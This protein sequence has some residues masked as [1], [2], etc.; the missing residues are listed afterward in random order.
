MRTCFQEGSKEGPATLALLHNYKLYLI[1]YCMCIVVTMETCDLQGL[2]FK[3]SILCSWCLWSPWWCIQ[4]TRFCS[5]FG[6]FLP[7]AAL[8]DSR[9]SLSDA[10]VSSTTR[11][12]TLCSD[13]DA[14]E[15]LSAGVW[16]VKLNR[17]KGDGGGSAVK[18]TICWQLERWTPGTSHL[19]FSFISCHYNVEPIYF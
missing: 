6:A 4:T 3:T 17:Q 2:F 14:E 16:A 7:T 9:G 11:T 12:G 18:F 1:N 8:L 13:G 19:W 15:V 10:G 5:D